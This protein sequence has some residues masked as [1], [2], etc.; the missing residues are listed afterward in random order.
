MKCFHFEISQIFFL[1]H[2]DG[3]IIFIGKTENPETFHADICQV[4]V[5]PGFI[6]F[7]V[8]PVCGCFLFGNRFGGQPL[9][10][11]HPEQA[12]YLFGGYEIELFHF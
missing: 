1:L 10:E 4:I 2:I 9:G 6:V 5:K 8:F 12:A 7:G 3:Y 11:L